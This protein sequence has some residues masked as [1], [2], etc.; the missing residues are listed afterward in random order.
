MIHGAYLEP[1]VVHGERR[2]HHHL[3]LHQRHTRLGLNNPN[4]LQLNPLIRLLDSPL[5]QGGLIL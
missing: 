3:A 1:L 4:D 2:L 5:P